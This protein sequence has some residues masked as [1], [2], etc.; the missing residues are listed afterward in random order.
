MYEPKNEVIRL[1]AFE[2][3]LL[4]RPKYPRKKIY[5][6]VRYRDPIKVKH[7]YHSIR[8]FPSYPFL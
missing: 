5:N 6:I 1:F 3:L 8:Q 7:A 4:T 2:F